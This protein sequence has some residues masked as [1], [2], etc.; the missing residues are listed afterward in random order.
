MFPFV[1][2]RYPLKMEPSFDPVFKPGLVFYHLLVKPD[3]AAVVL[4]FNPW[5]KNT[6]KLPVTERFA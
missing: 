6:F 1:V 4:L 3:N 5:N 2:Y